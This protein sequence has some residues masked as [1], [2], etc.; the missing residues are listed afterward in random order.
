VIPS[1]VVGSATAGA[2]AM[3]LGVT[4][5][6]PHGGIFVVILASNILGF[7]GSIALGAVVTAVLVTLLKSDHVETDES[8]TTTESTA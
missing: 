6:A 8:T 2:A 5:P 7:L 4:M 1:I 3:G